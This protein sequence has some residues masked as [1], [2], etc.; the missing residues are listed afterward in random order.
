MMAPSLARHPEPLARHPES[1]ARHPELVSGSYF[2]A[3][4][5]GKIKMLKQVQHDSVFCGELM[6]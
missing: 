1:L 6:P 5:D 3:T 2:L 4:V